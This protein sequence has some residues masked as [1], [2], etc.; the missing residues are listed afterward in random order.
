MQYALI[1]KYNPIIHGNR[2]EM[3]QLLT[4]KY[5]CL[6][7]KESETNIFDYHKMFEDYIQECKERNN[8]ITN[9]NPFFALITQRVIKGKYTIAIPRDD[10]ITKIQRLWRNYKKKFTIEYLNRRQMGL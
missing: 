5:I 2:K 8:D 4:N 7:T 3:I 9:E 10:I 1:E 6:D